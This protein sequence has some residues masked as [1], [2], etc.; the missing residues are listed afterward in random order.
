MFERAKEWGRVPSV[1][2]ANDPTKRNSYTARDIVRLFRLEE[3]FAS[4]PSAG[5]SSGSGGGK[6]AKAR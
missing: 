6:G 3:R 1:E 4:L 5:G 2:A